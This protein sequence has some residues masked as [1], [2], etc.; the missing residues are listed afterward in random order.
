MDLP[1]APEAQ[2]GAPGPSAPSGQPVVVSDK[3]LAT[4]WR[5]LAARWSAILDAD[6]RKESPLL[7]ARAAI[8]KELLATETGRKFLIASLDDQAEVVRLAAAAALLD[9]G[10]TAARL[11][12]EALAATHSPNAASA[13]IILGSYP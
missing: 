4:A 10:S 3:D 12:L 13:K 8:E 11:V 2:A 6:C 7:D 5:G 9:K 1:P